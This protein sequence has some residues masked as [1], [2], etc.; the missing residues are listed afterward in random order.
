MADT[1]LK[2]GI[3]M[4]ET[5][6]LNLKRQDEPGKIQEGAKQFEALL[7]SQMLRTA[8]EAGGAGGWLG[9]EEEAGQTLGEIAEQQLSQVIAGQGGFGLTKLIRQGLEHQSKAEPGTPKA[10]SD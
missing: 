2:L 5:P 7:I 3:S 4:L 8:R 1:T 10:A 6:T 9:T